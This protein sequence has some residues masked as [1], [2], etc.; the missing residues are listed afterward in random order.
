MKKPPAGTSSP[1]ARPEPAPEVSPVDAASDSTLHILARA[2]GGDEQAATILIERA[3]PT[4]R[5]WARGRLP[6]Y[7]RHEADTEDVVQDVFVR[8]LRRVKQFQHRTVGGLQAYLRQSVLNRIRDHIRG[9][10]RHGIR[11][12]VDE[13]IA[14][15]NPSPL[16]RAIMRQQLDR[17]L[18]ALRP[19]A[20]GRP[21]GGRVAPRARLHDRGDRPQARQVQGRGGN[22]GVPGDGAAGQRAGFRRG[23]VVDACWRFER[24]AF[25]S[26]RESPQRCRHVSRSIARG[27]R[28]P[29]CRR[30][31][32]RVVANAAG[33]PVA[34]AGGQPP[35]S[36]AAASSVDW[37]QRR[38]PGDRRR[39]AAVVG[40]AHR[41]GEWTGC[42]EVHRYRRQRRIP[43]ER[44]IRREHAVSRVEEWSFRRHP[45][46]TG[47]MR[48]L[49]P[50]MVDLLPAREPGAPRRPDGTLPAHLHGCRQLHDAT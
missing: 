11:T 39:V 36:S 49:Q 4:I 26:M 50:A 14:D 3:L 27:L 9:V 20:P 43:L 10:G 48:P 16:E 28:S 40:R 29:A 32:L 13:P 34:G 46:A 35:R 37:R 15:W 2:Q 1:A 23:R 31:R 30:R 38:R 24:V 21:A 6:H 19:S 42:R 7:A 12:G 25:T 8:M 22:D 18:E 17:F 45:A 5:R 41:S 33:R 47:P 44:T